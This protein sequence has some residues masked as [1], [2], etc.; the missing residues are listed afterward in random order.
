MR[1]RRGG[2]GFFV[3]ASVMN[4]RLINL[5]AVMDCRGLRGEKGFSV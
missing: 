2:E 4:C 5:I 1:G 3:S